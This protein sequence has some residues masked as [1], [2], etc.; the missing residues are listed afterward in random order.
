MKKPSYRAFTSYNQGLPGVLKNNVRISAQ[1]ADVGSALEFEAVWDTGATKSVITEKVISQCGLRPSGMVKMHG[2]TG[3]A[4]VETYLVKVGLPNNVFVGGVIAAKADLVGSQDVLIGMDI[5][6]LG[7]LA[8]SS[9][10]GRTSFSF[11]IP[12]T[13]RVDFLSPR[14]RPKGYDSF[15]NS[16]K[17]GRNQPCPCGSNLKYKNCCGAN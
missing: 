9:F 13:G 4:I 17:T 14:E 6:S 15:V 12:S 2:V 7:D 3:T 1:A 8:I 16:N 10:Q 11:R 5:I